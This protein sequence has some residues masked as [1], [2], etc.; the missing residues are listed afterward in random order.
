MYRKLSTKSGFAI[1]LL[2]VDIWAVFSLLYVAWMIIIIIHVHSNS[3]NILNDWSK[4]THYARSRVYNPKHSFTVQGWSTMLHLLSSWRHTLVTR[5]SGSKPRQSLRSALCL[6]RL[7]ASG[8]RSQH[9][10][11]Y[12]SIWSS[13][14]DYIISPLLITDINPGRSCELYPVTLL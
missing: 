10:P 3:P 4:Y 13:Q 7:A 12:G 6:I 11:V 14:N 5:I 9:S 2:F 1:L 8:Q